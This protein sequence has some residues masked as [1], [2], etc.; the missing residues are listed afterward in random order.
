MGLSPRMRGYQVYP[1]PHTVRAGSI[2]ADAGLPRCLVDWYEPE[3]V[4]PRGCGA[5]RVLRDVPHRDRG[6]S[7][8]MRGYRWRPRGASVPQRSIPADAGLPRSSGR[9]RPSN[10]VY[11]RGCGAT[12]ILPGA[13]VNVSGLSPRMRGYQWQEVAR[14]SGKRSIPA[15][16]G[17]PQDADR[18]DGTA[19]VYPRGCGATIGSLG[20]KSLTGGLSPRMRGYR[21]DRAGVSV[22][23]GSIPADAGLPAKDANK[24]RVYQVYP[25]GCGATRNGEAVTKST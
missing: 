17:L 23:R 12:P 7:P 9:P 8:R 2:P 24:N 10:G 11:P 16:A 1:P 22:P 3:E 4:Y 5:T 21:R 25:R 19:G 15:D 18:H 20:S 13:S 14:A 6:L